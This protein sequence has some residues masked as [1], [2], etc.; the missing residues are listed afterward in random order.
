MVSQI[1]VASDDLPGDRRIQV[2]SRLHALD[3]AEL[4]HRRDAPTD[5]RQLDVDDVAQLVLR[6]VADANDYLVAVHKRPLV[7]AGVAPVARNAR[8]LAHPTSGPRL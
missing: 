6:V 3:R 8:S 7:L 4:L 5:G 1:F 2:R